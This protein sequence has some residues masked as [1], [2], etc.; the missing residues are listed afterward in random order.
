MI[1]YRN[2]F[3]ILHDTTVPLN[4]HNAPWLRFQCIGIEE[5]FFPMFFNGRLLP[6]HFI[7][8]FCANYIE[9]QLKSKSALQAYKSIE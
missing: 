9:L 6:A 7:K 2:L 5:N 8:Y 3:Y 1:I 4:D